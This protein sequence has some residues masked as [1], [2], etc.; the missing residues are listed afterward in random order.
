LAAFASELL[1]CR[2]LET[3]EVAFAGSGLLKD[4]LRHFKRC[5]GL[6]GQ[7]AT[8]RDDLIQRLPHEGNRGRIVFLFL[9]SHKARLSLPL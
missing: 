8:I 3:V 9:L 2:A 4:M 1:E 7:E 6:S 5:D